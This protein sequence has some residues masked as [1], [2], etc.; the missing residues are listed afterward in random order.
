MTEDPRLSQPPKSADTATGTTTP[1]GAT[2]G[3]PLRGGTTPAAACSAGSGSDQASARAR[4]KGQCR[5][6]ASEPSRSA[7]GAPDPACG[8]ASQ[9]PSADAW[10]ASVL[11][12]ASQRVNAAQS[13]NAGRCQ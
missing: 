4:P 7:S 5:S 1:G 3:H 9:P 6:G 2:H 12:S 8:A 13:T 11:L 10:P